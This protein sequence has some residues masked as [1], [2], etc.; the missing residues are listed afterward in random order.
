MNQIHVPG[1]THRPDANP[2]LVL[3]KALDKT[4][5]HLTE[6]V[7]TTRAIASNTKKE[8]RHTYAID[9]RDEGVWGTYCLAC[10]D[11]A[12]EYIYPCKVGGIEPPP[13]HISILPTVEAD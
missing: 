5:Q 12:E 1:Q 9:K 2:L 8:S 6:L 13:S 3:A 10:S 11:A 4:N 7:I